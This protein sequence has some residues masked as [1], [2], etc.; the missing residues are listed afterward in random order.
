M[1][2]HV[3]VC[4]HICVYIYIYTHVFGTSTNLS[5]AWKGNTQAF[6]HASNKRCELL[7]VRD[8]WESS[9]HTTPSIHAL[10]AEHAPRRL[11]ALLVAAGQLLLVTQVLA[12]CTAKDVHLVHAAPLNKA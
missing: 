7:E 1:C 11:S 12:D 2:V 6:L 10:D 9:W 3:D 8:L 5:E 4:V